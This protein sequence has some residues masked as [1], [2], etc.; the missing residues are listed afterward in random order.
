MFSVLEIPIITVTKTD[1]AETS[2]QESSVPRSEVPQEDVAGTSGSGDGGSGHRTG[3]SGE[4]GQEDEVLLEGEE[5]TD[6][7]S[8]EG[9][10]QQQTVED[11]EVR[12]S[13]LLN[14]FTE[15]V[16]NVLLLNPFF[17]T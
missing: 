12:I 2:N 5:G 10:K 4:P 16:F 17:N 13:Y 11:N 15:S 14:F 6:G 8:S 7:V 9:E 1:E 3:T